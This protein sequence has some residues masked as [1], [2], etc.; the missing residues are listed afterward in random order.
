MEASREFVP[1]GDVLI[2]IGE[3][4][5]LLQTPV[6]TVRNWARQGKLPGVLPKIGGRAS[7]YRVNLRIL[8]AYLD[9]AVPVPIGPGPSIMHR[10][11]DVTQLDAAQQDALNASSP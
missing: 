3:A 2:S 11:D 5:K 6:T 4:A 8:R 9:S 7:T 10:P 1:E